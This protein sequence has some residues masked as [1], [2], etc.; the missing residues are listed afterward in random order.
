MKT[1]KYYITIII[2]VIA[3]NGG[4][5]LANDANDVIPLLEARINSA[6]IHTY[7]PE[8]KI[9]EEQLRTADPRQVLNLLGKY[10]ND[11]CEPVRDR[12]YWQ[13][14]HFAKL[15]PEP[16]IKQEV[17]FRLAKALIDPNTELGG[18]ISSRLLSFTEKDFS[19]AAKE[20]IRQNLKTNNRKGETIMLVGVANI[21]EEQPRLEG[22]LID[23]LAYQAE[24][25]K[26][27]KMPWY[28]TLGWRA[29]LALARMGVKEDVDKCVGL[30]EQEIDNNK[31]WRLLH[32]LGYIRQPEAIESLK[33]YF[34]SDLKLPPMKPDGWGAESYSRYIMPIL[35]ENLSNFPIKQKKSRGFY[36]KE[37]IELCRKW[38][39][40][41]KEWKI[42]R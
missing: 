30:I 5:I 39:S 1:F 23:E 7:P 9:S 32:D 31:N 12:A 19:P 14:V 37:E 4:N 26:T 24:A 27:G 29:H 6:R 34:L 13:E 20:L 15:R 16:W 11:P 21:I 22:L 8:V 17:V 40:E 25:D 41:Q 18:R 35:D 33:K 38:M 42:I 36:T 3:L 28:F 2:C 10:E